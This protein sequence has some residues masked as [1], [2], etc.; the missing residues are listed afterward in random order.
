MSQDD[1]KLSTTALARKLD[2]PAQQLFATLRDYGWIRRSADT[3]VLLPKGEFE[4]GSYQQSRRYGRYIVWPQSLDHHPL[5][6]AIES[7]QRIT[8][9][10]M[11]RYYPRLHARQ[12]NRALAELGLQH[13]SVLGWELT[14]LGRSMGGQQEESEA[15]GAFYVT[16][17]HEIVDNPV[18]HRELTRQSDQI[19]TPEPADANAEPDLFANADTKI[20]CEGIDGHVLATPLQMRVCNWLY[21]AQL[22]HAYRRLL[23]IEEQ[24]HADFYLPAGNVYID[25]WQEDAS[26][27]ELRANL[28][29]REIY[30]EMRL[31]SLEVKEADAENLDEILGRGLLTFGIRC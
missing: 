7:N 13:H 26:A 8:A 31:H 11:R 20:S 21:L 30:R 19:P 10:S 29:K 28:H 1:G 23:P 27:A 24:V 2:I 22:A 15:S 16:W 17:P 4:G 14:A 6:A 9:A 12:I 3:W 25:C 18:V 5:L